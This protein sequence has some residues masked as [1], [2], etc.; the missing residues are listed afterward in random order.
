M[1][2]FV[3]D[4][5]T[6]LNVEVRSFNSYHLRIIAASRKKTDRRDAYWIAKGKIKPALRR[7]GQRIFTK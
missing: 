4:L 7:W 1:A 6:A 2:Y 3:H 5:L